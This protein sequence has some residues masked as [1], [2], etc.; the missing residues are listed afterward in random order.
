MHNKKSSA[1]FVYEENNFVNTGNQRTTVLFYY[2][3]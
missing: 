3:I 1:R 2:N